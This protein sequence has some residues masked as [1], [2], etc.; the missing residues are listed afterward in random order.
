[1][2][3]VQCSRH[4]PQQETF[5]CQHIVHTLRDRRPRGFFWALDPDNERSDAWCTSCNA[6]V[7]A[8]G[9][10][11]SEESEAAADIKILCG[12]CYDEAK[13]LNGF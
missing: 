3:E 1:M 4:G 9:G 7:A 2:N 8:N 5:V 10:D 13:R 11:W 6:L 12:M